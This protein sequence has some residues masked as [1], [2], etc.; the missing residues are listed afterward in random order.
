MHHTCASCEE[1]SELREAGEECAG[2]KEGA[3]KG[4]GPRFRGIRTG[5]ACRKRQEGTR[6]LS[7]MADGAGPPP[8]QWVSAAASA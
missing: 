6:S 8:N 1:K 3:M 5:A 2:E 7:S 4:R